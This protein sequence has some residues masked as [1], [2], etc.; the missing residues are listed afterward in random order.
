MDETQQSLKRGSQV[1]AQS[2]VK[3]TLAGGSGEEELMVSIFGSIPFS[4]CKGQQRELH[5]FW[6]QAQEWEGREELTLLLGSCLDNTVR[7]GQQS[8]PEVIEG[9]W[10]WREKVSQEHG[11]VKE[12]NTIIS[13]ATF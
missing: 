5:K 9:S 4:V 12:I 11:G 3:T 10:M 6:D 7:A 2:Q 13:P 1:T 8:L